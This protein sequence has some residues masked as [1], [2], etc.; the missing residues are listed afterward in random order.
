M[1]NPIRAAC[2]F[3]GLGA[4]HLMLATLGLSQDWPQWRGPNRDGVVHGVKVPGKWPKTLAEEWKVPVGEGVASPVVV[5]SNVYVFTREKKG[6][7][8]KS[9]VETGDEVVRC[10]DLVSG[11]E[12]WRSEPYPATYKP[13]VDAN[14]P[15]PRS[16][17]LVAD[18]RVFTL[19]MGGFLSCLD[20]KTGKLVWRKESRSLTYGG[21]NSPLAADGLCI[22]HVGDQKAG[23][24]TA[25]DA[26]TGEVKWCYADGTTAP[27]GSPILGTLAGE[28]QVVTLTHWNFLGVSAATGKK[29]W[30]FRG[31]FPQNTMC[32]TPVRYKDLLIFAGC[33]EPLRAIRLEKGDKGILRDVWKAKGLPLY[34]SSPVLVG[35]LLFGMSTRH[36]GCFFCLDA[37]SGK[38]LWESD[39]RQ[40]ANASIVNAGSVLLF[41]TERGRLLIVKPSATAYEPIAEYKV[42]D[43]DTHAHP[44][45]LGDR[46]LIKDGTMLRSF[47]IA[48]DHGKE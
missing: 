35:D 38:T 41:L 9:G 27:C 48:P 26:V 20:A 4:T 13:H 39:G 19:G 10:L 17:P 24:L 45:F 18:G 44:V 8:V 31:P 5:G 1:R 21:S 36:Q 34:Y 16:T 25:F 33:G 28:R 43:T 46:I 7:D 2:F 29:L 12:R 15:W 30:E 23:G 6:K 40:G 11:K 14:F 32:N 47:R 42:S 22:V 37:N 3:L